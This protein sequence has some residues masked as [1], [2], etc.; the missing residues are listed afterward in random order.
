M[1]QPACVSYA[2]PNAK[3]TVIETSTPW[4]LPP[5]IESKISSVSYDNAGCHTDFCKQ[6]TSATFM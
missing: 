6:D 2:S 1:D 5:G 3:D 4:D